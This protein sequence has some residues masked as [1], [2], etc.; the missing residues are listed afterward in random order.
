MSDQLSEWPWRPR[1]SSVK[2]RA[3]QGVGLFSFTSGP[4]ALDYRERV[5]V[6]IHV[7][8]NLHSVLIQ[9]IPTKKSGVAGRAWSQRVGLNACRAVT[10]QMCDSHITF[11]CLRFRARAP[12]L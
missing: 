3:Q 5:C 4:P 1:D 6:Y 10:S 8:F 12:G 7:Y 2:C 9:Y 11:P